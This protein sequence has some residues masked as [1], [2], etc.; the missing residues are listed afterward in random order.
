MVN[1]QFFLELNFSFWFEENLGRIGVMLTIQYLAQKWPHQILKRFE[2]E[3]EKYL[4]PKVW[5]IFFSNYFSFF[6]QEKKKFQ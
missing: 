3:V 1:L 4:N 5:K 2:I 6:L